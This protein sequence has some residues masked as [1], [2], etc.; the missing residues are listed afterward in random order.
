MICRTK[1]GGPGSNCQREK[2]NRSFFKKRST[3]CDE[4]FGNQGLTQCVKYSHLEGKKATP[5]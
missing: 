2:R 3:S 5:D 4:R 1:K